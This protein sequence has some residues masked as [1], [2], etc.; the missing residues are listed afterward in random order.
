[1]P[2]VL[3]K[4]ERKGILD[5]ARNHR[6]PMDD[7]VP[8]LEGVPTPSGNTKLVKGDVWRDIGGASTQYGIKRVGVAS[9]GDGRDIYVCGADELAHVYAFWSHDGG[10]TWTSPTLISTYN[11]YGIA[12]LVLPTGRVVFYLGLNSSD[13]IVPL[14]SDDQ[15]ATWVSAGAVVQR[16]TGTSSDVEAIQDGWGRTFLLFAGDGGTQ[17]NYT[18]DA[19]GIAGWLATSPVLDN[20]TT[21]LHIALSS[22]RGQQIVAVTGDPA[23]GA[24]PKVFRSNHDPVNFTED[25][26]LPAAS[27]L[28][29]NWTLIDR[30]AFYLLY[31]SSGVRVHVADDYTT[32]WQQTDL[33]LAASNTVG[34]SGIDG[35]GYKTAPINADEFWLF[36]CDT[37]SHVSM[38]KVTITR[39]GGAQ[40]SHDSLIGVL[41]DQHHKQRH[42]HQGASD[43]A[44]PIDINLGTTGTLA[45]NRVAAID[46]NTGTTGTLGEARIDPTITRDTELVT[47]TSGTGGTNIAAGKTYTVT[48]APDAGYPDTGGTELTDGVL[49]T[50]SYTDAAWVGWQTT[51]P[52]IVADLGALQSI[53]RVRVGALSNTTPG[54]YYPDSLAFYGSSDNVNFTL[55]GSLDLTGQAESSTGARSWFQLALTS[56]AQYRYVKIVV[57]NANQW[58]FLDEIEV[59]DGPDNT[60]VRAS[61]VIDE[62]VQARTGL[63][64]NYSNLDQR[65]DSMESLG[66]SGG[67]VLDVR[68]LVSILRTNFKVDTAHSF[69]KNA[70]KGMVIDVFSDDKGIDAAKSSGYTFDANATAVRVAGTGGS[71]AQKAPATSPL[72]RGVSAFVYAPWLSKTVLFG[73]YGVDP[74]AGTPLNDTWYYDGTDWVEQSPATKP[75]ARWDHR[76]AADTVRSRIV[77]FGG[78]DATID[79]NDTWEYDGTDWAQKAPANAPSARDSYALGFDGNRGVTVLFGG[80]SGT[81]RFNDTWEWDGTNWTAR[82]FATA[83]SARNFANI[84][85]DPNR[86][87]LVL[88]GGYDGTNYLDDTWEYDGTAWTLRSPT[89]KPPARGYHMLAAETAVSYVITFGGYN[90]TYLGDTWEYDSATWID[91]APATAPAARASMGV[92]YD[93]TRGVVVA[94]GGGNTTTY[95]ADTWE[96]TP[97]S[98][99]TATVISTS[100]VSDIPSPGRA[101]MTADYNVSNGTIAFYISRDAGTTWT[102]MTLDAIIDIS[103]QPAGSVIVAKCVMTGDATLFAWAWGW[104]E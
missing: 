2:D 36:T 51:P 44:D 30:S 60:A 5:Q 52:T 79:L 41:P 69:S 98:G 8:P 95:Y 93:S 66:N 26:P 29:G 27:S 100:D 19:G 6:R 14:Y 81:T 34:G 9:S 42:N 64:T 11:P 86:K 21:A 65:L 82:T 87:V 20:R 102:Q 13:W 15:G 35:H 47:A 38:A 17:Y 4:P 53:Y 88:F 92:A 104:A 63:T 73:G 7:W 24:T 23:N 103:A 91:R 43:D 101:Y 70:L 40:I 58:T 77:M 54:I 16:N 48:P 28:W 67:S 78:Y 31:N 22:I 10:V 61:A 12:G 32:W 74:S 85:Y 62:V 39:G 33:V 68:A 94:F 57:T 71:W 96:W 3:G 83:P 50:T 46:I 37:N 1:M 76:L 55:I 72:R 18:D 49:G 59:Y 90:G 80:K 75:S 56:P 89:T 97:A 99:G 25:P 45:A 84:V